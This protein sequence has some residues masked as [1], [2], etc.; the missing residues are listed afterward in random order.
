MDDVEGQVLAARR[1][2]P[3]AWKELV[4]GHTGL[5]WSVVRGFRFDEETSKDVFQTVWLKLAENLDRIRE[6]AKLAG[7]LGQTTRNECVGIV[8]QRG[9]VLPVEEVA[10]LGEPVDA[11]GVTIPEPGER[12]ER[13]ESRAAVAAAFDRLPDRCQRL[14]RLLLVDPPVSYEQISELLDIP[15]GS[16]GPTRARCLESL[17]SS[18]EIFR[19]SGGLP[20]S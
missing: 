14:L 4:D 10:E 5:V 13:E 6:P 18:P 20:S 9:R 8:R 12:L 11:S 16:I 2:D 17:R 3:A 7:W 15:V 19:I 1:G